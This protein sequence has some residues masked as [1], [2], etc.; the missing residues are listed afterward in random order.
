MLENKV[1]ISCAIVGGVTKREHTPYVPILP[2]E[3]VQQAVDAYRAGAAVVHLHVRE[4]DE[5]NT[6]NF[7]RFKYI[8][9]SIRKQC[10]VVINLTSACFNTSIADRVRPFYELKPELASLDAGTMNWAYSVVFENS[11]EFLNVA[12]QKMIEVGVK[13]EI[14]IFDTGMIDNAKHLMKKGLIEDPPYFQFVLGAPGGMP[15]TAKALLFLLESIPAN[16][17]WSAFGIGGQ[18]HLDVM[19]AAL[20]LGG[21]IRVGLEDNVYMSKGVLAKSNAEMVERAVRIVKEFN[22][23]PATPDE[24]REILK[25]KEKK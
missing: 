4:D 2:D 18:G 1:I 7:D 21:N 17:N 3:I 16:S 11:P 12:S 14:E 20:A 24:A 9:E 6:M 22:K 8:T 10:D 15:A 13:P 5:T 19:F 23:L 25:L